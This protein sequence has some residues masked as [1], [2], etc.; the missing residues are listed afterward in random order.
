MSDNDPFSA[1]ESDRTV[2]KPS[3]GRGARPAQPAAPTTPGAPLETAGLPDLPGAAGFSPL[4]QA[5]APLLAAAP[6]IRSMPQH[7]N[8]AALRAA[9]VEGVRKF[10]ATARSAGLPNEQVIAGR[11]VLCAF[12]DE[13]AS[14]TP[15]GGSGAWGSQSLLV[16]FH[17]EAFGGEKVFQLMGKLAENVPTNRNLLELMYM[18]LALGFEGRY[19]VLDNGRAQLESVRERLAQMLRQNTPAV[20]RELSPAWPGVRARDA[21][22][23]DGIPVWTVAAAAALLLMVLFVALRFAIN[24]RSNPTFDALQALKVKA[25]PPPPPPVPAPAPRLTGL[26]KPDIDAKLVEVRDFAD[27]SVIVIR[28]DGFFEPAS[29]DIADRVKPLLGRIAA[30]LNELPGPVLVT[31][32]T[33]SQ[34]I[35]SVRFP[36]NWHLSQERALSVKALLATTLKQPERVRAEGRADSEAVGDNKTAAG[37][38]ENRRV[39][40]VL[41][42]SDAER[43]K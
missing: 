17:N 43:L 19:R 22:L 3:A 25:A 40:I 32:H 20:D 28:G 38:A 13:S 8:P 9:L 33:D 4:I 35:R 24:D 41:T 29:A 18:A 34:A 26:L 23:R 21:R 37:R 31:G 16:H 15:W 2:I 30:A 6:R 11:Y 42:A 14:S 7:P 12:L 36:S 27:R 1:F 10:E 39:E 5:A